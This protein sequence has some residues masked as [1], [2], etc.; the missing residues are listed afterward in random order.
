MYVTTMLSKKKFNAFRLHMFDIG[1]AHLH[2]FLL[3]III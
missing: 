1:R 2:E 3:F